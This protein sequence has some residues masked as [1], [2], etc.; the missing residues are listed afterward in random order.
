[1]ASR[2]GNGAHG[3]LV[4][5]ADSPHLCFGGWLC[6][7]PST[8]QTH[9]GS[10]GLKNGSCGAVVVRASSMAPGCWRRDKQ[11]NA[12]AY[13]SI[14]NKG[15]KGDTE[16]QVRLSHGAGTTGHPHA[17][18]RRG[19]SARTCKAEWVRD[20]GE[21]LTLRDSRKKTHGSIFVS[22]LSLKG[23]WDHKKQ[24]F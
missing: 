5:S 20:A 12:T 4:G 7:L 2:K 13:T 14:S 11:A 18:A 16:K 15:S 24:E 23:F 10:G 9:L 19:H 21:G 6:P 3:R 17:R 8:Q 22:W 1:M